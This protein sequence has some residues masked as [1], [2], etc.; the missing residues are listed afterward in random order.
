MIESE[1]RAFV[2]ALGQKFSS[3]HRTGWV[4]STCPLAFA[5]HTHGG[6]DKATTFG[7]RVED[8]EPFCSCFACDFHGRLSDLVLELHYLHADLPLGQLLAALDGL[9]VADIKQTPAWEDG[10]ACLPGVDV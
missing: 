7:V 4:V 2:S 10:R 6:K 1:I 9:P 5:R 3:Q 8:G